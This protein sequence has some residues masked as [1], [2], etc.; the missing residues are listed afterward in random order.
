TVLELRSSF[1]QNHPKIRKS[2]EY[3]PR[4]VSDIV[5]SPLV[6]NRLRERF[7]T[8]EEYRNLLLQKSYSILT[9]IDSAN[10]GGR[11]PYIFA[12]ST[13]YCADR[14]L[15]KKTGKKP[16]LTQKILAK[17]AKVAEYSIR[18]HYTSVLKPLILLKQ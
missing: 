16:I 4:I 3:L 15:S 2:E 17:I 9:E 11:N 1:I 7:L 12:V 14:M 10:R 8:A 13:V 18:D 5:S 6:E